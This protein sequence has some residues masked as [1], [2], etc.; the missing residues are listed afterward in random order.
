V[1]VECELT[2]V[3]QVREAIKNYKYEKCSEKSGTLFFFMLKIL[4]EKNIGF[5]WMFFFIN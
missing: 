5:K 1:T 2:D 4:R 3:S